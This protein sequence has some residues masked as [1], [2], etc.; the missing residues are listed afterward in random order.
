MEKLKPVIGKSSISSLKF[1]KKSDFDK[2]LNFIKKQTKELEGI[3]KPKDDRLKSILKTGAIGLGII[4]FGGLLGRG[5]Q[6]KSGDDFG[7]AIGRRSN[8]PS[9][10]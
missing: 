8:K 3:E 4:G 7:F 1:Q 5:K 9:T 2:F 6:G 10:Q